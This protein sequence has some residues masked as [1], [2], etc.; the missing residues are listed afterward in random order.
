V[1]TQPVNALT[2]DSI[3]FRLRRGYPAAALSRVA[4][5]ADYKPN[6]NTYTM[7]RFIDYFR[8]RVPLT[9]AAERFLRQ[10]SRVQVYDRLNHFLTP[11]VRAPYWCVVLEGVAC[12]Y[13]LDADGQR[14]IHWFA[15][16]MQGF[17]GVRHLY[18]PRPAGHYIQFIEVSRVLC[19]PALRMREAKE[20]FAEVSE[21][22]HVMKQQYIDRQDKLVEVLQQ[23]SAYKRYTMFLATFPELAKRT[24][25]EQ[26]MDFIN[27][28][29][30]TYYR[31]L[32]RY[33]DERRE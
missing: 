13:T 4:N 20:R 6:A 12:G 2:Y 30:P 23:E 32:K 21:V 33:R 28:A 22:L 27:I 11:E 10:H 5:A 31:V 1:R 29:R 17:A 16:E 18:T 14:R 24:A 25:P 26:E 7:N 8:R 15:T 3:I 9:D 19:I